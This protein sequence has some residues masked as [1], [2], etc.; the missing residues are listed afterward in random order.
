MLPGKHC[1]VGVASLEG[2]ATVLRVCQRPGIGCSVVERLPADQRA[3]VATER[4]LSNCYMSAISSCH[5][6]ILEQH[7][8]SFE[9]NSKGSASKTTRFAGKRSRHFENSEQVWNN[10]GPPVATWDHKPRGP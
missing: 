9:R 2:N 1:A 8:F 10:L 3:R 5:S 7:R 4:V 6:A